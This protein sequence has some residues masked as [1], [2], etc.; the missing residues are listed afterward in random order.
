MSMMPINQLVNY[1]Q[2]HYVE[3]SK[4]DNAMDTKFNYIS[5]LSYS[6]SWKKYGDH[7][8]YVINWRRFFHFSS[9]FF[10]VSLNNIR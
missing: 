4:R 6:F 7:I 9:F 1:L 2:R 8:S 3:P 5:I 10:L